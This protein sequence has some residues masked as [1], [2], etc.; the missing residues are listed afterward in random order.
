[1]L[2][3]VLADRN[4]VRTVDDDVGGHQHGISEQADTG[5]DAL[6][7][8]LLVRHRP[9]QQAHVRHRA[10][11]P[12]EFGNLGN[13]GLAEE[14]G[15][16][17][18][19][20]EGQVIQ[21]DVQRV[22]PQCFRVVD[23]RQ[24]VIVGDE[25]EALRLVLQGDVLANGA[26]V[27]AEV[28]LARRLDAAE[29]ALGRGSGG[30]V[31]QSRDDRLAASFC[32]RYPGNARRSSRLN[33]AAVALYNRPFYRVVCSL[34]GARDMDRVTE[35]LMTALK[36]ALLDPSSEHRLY[37]SG[38]LE[39][40]FPGKIGFSGEAAAQA[41]RDGLLEIARTETKG[42]TVLDWVRLT[43]RGVDFVHEQ[44]SPVAALHELRDLLR[45]NQRAI[46]VWLDDMRAGLAAFDQ[47]LALDTQKWM[48]RLDA[49][50]LRVDAALKHLEAA[51]PLIPP[52]LASSQPW[53]VDAVNY[54]DRRHDGGAPEDCPLPELFNALARQHP[55]L[56]IGAFHEG[57][58]RLSER[59][60]VQLSPA[61]GLL[62]LSQP[63]FALLRDGE[64]LYFA[65]R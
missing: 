60:V 56:S 30:H 6:L 61:M 9:L 18:V 48:Q 16:V 52:E 3:L 39:G 53:V 36:E 64:V 46:P 63:E 23:G 37:R 58:K 1:M 13:I 20:S 12:G 34:Q 49:L 57:L 8:F 65:G 10:E 7:H 32:E 14:D 45:A 22:L 44:E 35:I 33:N 40:L 42:K 24:G 28:Q 51:K 41:L 59:R 31:D 11:N 38:K 50:T 27:V 5:V 4:E 15:A 43:A 2:H 17:G 54:L 19:E 29:D 55:G 26:E 21:G 25:I 47:R 62:N